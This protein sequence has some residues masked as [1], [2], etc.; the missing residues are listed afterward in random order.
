MSGDVMDIKRIAIIGGGT[1]GWLAANHLGFELKAEPDVEITVIES[2]D[3]P[4]AH[5]GE[6]EHRF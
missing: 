3:I 6:H 5:S 2:A 1:A 4:T